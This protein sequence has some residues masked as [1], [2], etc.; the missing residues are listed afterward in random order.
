[1]ELTTVYILSQ[2]F[3]ILKYGLLA[4]TYFLK[5]RKNIL[6]IG[7]IMLVL[8]GISYALVNAWTGFAMVIVAIIRNLYLLIFDDKKNPEKITKKDIIFLI[9]IYIVTIILTI[10]SYEGFL[11]LL[12]VFATSIYTYSVW[13]KKTI[14]YKILGI[15]TSILFVIYHIYIQSLFGIILEGSLLIFTITGFILEWKEKKKHG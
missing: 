8:T 2:I 10:P 14:V 11:S 5:S 7:F 1:M 9:A 13:Q 4:Y 12:V 3:I 6:V 15:F